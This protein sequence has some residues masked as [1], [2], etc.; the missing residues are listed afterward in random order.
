MPA[1]TVHADKPPAVAGQ[2]LLTVHVYSYFHSL[3]SQLTIAGGYYITVQQT[4]SSISR[5]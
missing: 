1:C 2:K 3:Y 4:K 5:V